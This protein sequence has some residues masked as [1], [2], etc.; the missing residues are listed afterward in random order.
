MKIEDKRVTEFVH[1]RIKKRVDVDDTMMKMGRLYV[2]VEGMRWM[3]W[4]SQIEKP[5]VVDSISGMLPY[6]SIV[7]FLGVS[8]TE[9]ESE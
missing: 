8:R 7:P 3:W 9:I 5:D 1:L 2:G 6:L 4:G